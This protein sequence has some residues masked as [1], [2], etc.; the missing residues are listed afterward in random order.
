MRRTVA[1]SIIVGLLFL[2]LPTAEALAGR[3]AARVIYM[4]EGPR[5][6]PIWI[7]A[8]AAASEKGD[9]QWRLFSSSEQ[10]SL[11]RFLADSERLKRAAQ[12][13]PGHQPSAKSELDCPIV[14]AA[15]DEGRID[16][17]PNGSFSD[18]TEQALA[19]YSGKIESISQGFFDGLPSSLLEVRV[20]EAFRSSDLLGGEKVLVPYAFA[21]F[22]VG[23]ATF[24]GGSDAMFQP[25]VG[26]RVLVFIY[27]PPL[28]AA[29]T[30]VF[31][32]S[33]ELLF[34]D[35]DGR[36]V[37]PEPLKTDKDLAVADSLDDLENLLRGELMETG[38]EKE[39]I[40]SSG[41]RYEQ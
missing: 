12:G 32:R 21:R 2:A 37:V 35:S 22:K 1:R 6:E 15:S 26:D 28:D 30:L 16:P 14:L 8:E 11:R 36:L 4:K 5:A 38:A 17:K 19:I 31:P 40:P 33:P 3:D 25:T 39:R 27:D 34:Q 7:S 20:T 23:Q 41:L 10:G 29:R 18:L 13:S 24:C 9:L